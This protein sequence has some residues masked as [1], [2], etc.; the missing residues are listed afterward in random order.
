[1]R[2][3]LDVGGVLSRAF[4]TYTSQAGVV[5]PAALVVFVAVG[6]ISGFLFWL[7]TFGIGGGIGVL[8]GTLLAALVA[9]AGLYLYQGMVV[10]VVRDVQDGRR[11][12]SMGQLFKSAAPAIL[13]L[14]GAGILI[15]LAIQVPTWLVSLVSRP[16]GQLVG[17]VLGLFLATIWAVVAP[18]I[19][20]ERPGVIHAL[21]RSRELV[22]GSGW[23]VFAVIVILY[24]ILG[25]GVGL[26]VLILGAITSSFIG[27]GIGA[28]IALILAAPIWALA[29]ATMYF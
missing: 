5:L 26:F 13:P 14:I 16:L 1:M 19:V 28:L 21:G 18:V 2:Q 27:L 15:A 22:R 4:Q 17:F 23:Q 7:G 11:D 10:Q 29:V 25:I 24:L 3:K 8:L 9:L 20:V 6:I 12:L